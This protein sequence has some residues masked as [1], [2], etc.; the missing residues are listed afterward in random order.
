MPERRAPA[1]ASRTTRTTRSAG[2]AARRPR[3]AERAARRR[4]RRL[5]VTLGRGVVL[6]CYGA[7]LTVVFARAWPGA[8]FPE[9]RG[10]VAAVAVSA[11]AGVLIARPWALFLPI[12]LVV[13]G[14]WDGYGIFSGIVL[15]VV[16]GPYALTGMAG[17]ILIGRVLRRPFRRAAPST[18]APPR[19]PAPADRTQPF[20]AVDNRPRRARRREAPLAAR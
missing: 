7:A 6:G 16:G 11:V 3:A 12:A 2:A 5:A 20:T 15:L 4:R 18:V 10:L 19:R 9:P 1:A 13:V 14:S 17:G 8:P